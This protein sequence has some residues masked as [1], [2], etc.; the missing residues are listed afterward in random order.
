MHVPDEQSTILAHPALAGCVLYLRTGPRWAAREIHPEGALGAH[1]P[2][3]G[4][5]AALAWRGGAI[6]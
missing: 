1:R 6:R 2:V 5:P 3:E 4:D